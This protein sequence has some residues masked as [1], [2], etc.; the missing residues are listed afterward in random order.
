MG[1]VSAERALKVVFCWAEA[2]GYMGACWRA[3]GAR[4]GVDVHVIHSE[5]LFHVQTNQFKH[6]LDGLSN[7]MFDSSSRD[8]LPWLVEA[9][10]RQRPDVIV[11]CGWIYWPYTRLIRSPSLHGVRAIMGMDSPWRGTLTQRLG[12]LRLASTL[13][14]CD[15][16]VTAGERSSIYARRLGV[17]EQ[18]LR[19]GYYG[20]DYAMFSRVARS[21]TP[22]SWARK[23]LFVGRYV[24]QKDLGTLSAAYARY[25]QMVSDPWELTCCGHGPD[26]RLIA[27]QPGVSDLGFKQPSELPAIFADHGAFVMASHFEPWGVVIAEAAGSGLPLLCTT[28]CGAALDLVRPYY[29]GITV[30]PRDVDGLARAM[31]WIHEHERELPVMGARAHVMA[32][33]FSAEAWAERWHNYVLEAANGAARG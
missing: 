21:R 24:E 28:A 2:S 30:A 31:R 7:E 17:P 29:N 9:V 26:A 12:R 13:E 8:V 32:E 19:T 22:A 10:S 18:R 25:R 3:L 4:P 27:N 5:Q 1:A 14:R 23:F 6:E 15:M 11:L 33:A 20:F 16:V